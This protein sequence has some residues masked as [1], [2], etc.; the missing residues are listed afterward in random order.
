MSWLISTERSPVRLPYKVF[1]IKNRFFSLTYIPVTVFPPSKSSS[2]RFPKIYP[3]LP[4]SYPHFS[5]EKSDLQKT[6]IKCGKNK[7]Q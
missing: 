7:K 1:N 2:S 5:L 6:A 3:P 4:T